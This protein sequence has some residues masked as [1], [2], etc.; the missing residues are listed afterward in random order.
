M[1]LKIASTKRF[2]FIFAI[3]TSVVTG[4]I[5]AINMFYHS[6]K[7]VFFL[8]TS[9]L[10]IF[11]LIYVAGFFIMNNFIYNKFKPLYE[12]LYKE[13]PS[14]EYI[15]K[16]IEEDRI[17]DELK[18][19]VL[20]WANRQNREINQL[21]ANA[22][23]RKEFLGNVS[24]ELK[25]P[26]FNIQGYLST[27]MDGAI[28]DPEINTRYLEKADK[29]VNRLISI[30]EDLSTI[31]DLESGEL[32]LTYTSFDIYEVVKE[33]IDMQEITAKKYNN[34]L[35]TPGHKKAPVYVYADKQRIFQV[36]S[37][38]VANAIKYGKNGGRTWIYVQPLTYTVKIQIKDNG[39][40]IPQKHASR[41][42][43]RF[44]R[45]DKSRSREH[46]G[47]GLGLSIVKHIIYAHDTYI[48]VDSAPGQGTK[49]TFELDRAPSS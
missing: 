27:L 4:G 42:F 21:K 37:N 13:P 14:K 22:R 10:I 1:K 20:N 34:L 26:I 7:P 19:V 31:T 36:I 33:I 47:T 18:D 46:G 39:I 40:G 45:V 43:E 28:D 11:L 15:Y 16:Q 17:K 12:T 44:Y 6:N 41:I 29:N 25:T 23:Y 2:A 8:V 32:E 3:T 5:I 30:A 24:H 49:F 48:N 38:L 35:L 9:L